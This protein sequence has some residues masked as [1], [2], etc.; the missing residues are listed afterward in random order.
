MKKKIRWLILFAWLLPGQVGFAQNSILINFGSATC[1][2]AN[3]PA[4]SIIRDPLNGA[5]SVLTSCDLTAQLPDFYNVFIAYNPKNNKIYVADIRDGVQTKIWVLDMGL[6]GDI[7]CPATIPVAPTYSYSYISNNFEFDNNGDLWSFSNYNVATGQCNMDKFDVNTG[8]VIN[9]RVLQFPA[10]NFPTTIQSGDLT[11]L[12]NGRMFA[13][14]GVNPCQLY[15]V[16]N[17]S[18]T[19]GI[20]SATYLQSLPKSCYG[21]AYLN[22]QLELTGNDPNSCY[23]FD[24]DISANILGAQKTFQNGQSPVDNTSLTPSIGVTKQLVNAVSINSNTADLTYEIFVK[25][26]GNVILNNINVSDDLSQAFGA[27]NVSNVHANLV[28]GANAGGLFLNPF[29]NGTSFKNLLTNGQNL[30]NKTAVNADYFFKLQVHCRVT[31]LSPVIT[32]YNSAIGRATIG[33]NGNATLI[34][35]ADSSNNG[36]ESVVDPNNN[37]NAGEAGENEPT[38]FNFGTLP[39]RFISVNATILNKTS[40]L[41]NWVVATP[42]VNAARFEIEYSADGNVWQLLSRL[43]IDNVNQAN[44]QF[45]HQNMP[46]GNLYYRIKQ[47]DKDG[48]YVYSRIVLLRNKLNETGYVVFPNPANNILQLSSP[49]NVSRNTIIELYDATGRRLLTKKMNASTEEINTSLLPAG[50]YLLKISH[51]DEVQNYKVLIVH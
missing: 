45:I 38:P 15:E 28:P 41:V 31:N 44:F 19:S 12:P 39:V 2:N 24:Y 20:A 5:P 47:V 18:S 40:A 14:L 10:G 43:Y 4:F 29:Y 27:G 21:I 48:S 34:N 32:Y 37:G 9:T 46:A 51:N 11:I 7:T 8:N 1:S 6:P 17:Y 33:N 42:M 49:Y 26:L 16:N 36:T 13:T 35:A 50:A 30:A 3:A 22:G 25:N 23:Y